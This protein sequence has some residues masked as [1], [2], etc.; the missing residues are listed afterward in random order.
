MTNQS[1]SAAVLAV[2]KV[3]RV[4]LQGRSKASLE[5][6]LKAAQKLMEA[7]GNEDFTLQDVSKAGNV[8]IGSIYLRF[9]SKENLVRAVIANHLEQIMADEAQMFCK[10]SAQSQNLGEFVI[11]FVN[12]YAEFLRHHAPMMRL[13]MERAR[14]D[15][16]VSGPG[17][18][19]ASRA[20]RLTRNGMMAYSD[21][22]G[23]NDR[24][25]RAL[26]AF[27]A[28]FSTLARHLALGSSAETADDGVEWDVLKQEL[29]RMCLAY[30]KNS[31]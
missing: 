20:A 21:E 11:N 31:D 9:E 25:R 30:L 5:R 24:E 23:G 13:S 12:N 4:P 10:I 6:M 1:T 26:S 18:V 27:D 8:S 17:K 15:P 3:S 14:H 22:F 29:A 28:I 19:A 2:E 7:S 16:L